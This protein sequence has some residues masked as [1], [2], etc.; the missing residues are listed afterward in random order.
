MPYP[1]QCGVIITRIQKAGIGR[2][3]AIAREAGRKPETISRDAQI[4]RAVANGS[5]A[6]AAQRL[7]LSTKTVWAVLK[8][9]ERIA[10]GILGGDA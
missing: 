2:C 10:N 6:S 5:I 1:S 8:R 3:I 4:L 7:Q 9:Y